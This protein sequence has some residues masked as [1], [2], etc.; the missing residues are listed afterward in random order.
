MVTITAVTPGTPAAKMENQVPDSLKHKHFDILL[1]VQNQISR[2]INV[3]ASKYD[4]RT[5]TNALW[6]ILLW[7]WLT[8]GIASIVW[9]H[10][11]C[12]RIGNELQRRQVPK[13][14][15]ASDFW[16]WCIL[17]A[18]IYVG[19]F[20]FVHKFMHAMNHLNADYNKKG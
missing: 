4:G 11:I 13:T 15:G 8:G 10:C 12:N 1:D 18:L 14:F 9:T 16:G 17:G 6:I 19:P 3:V 7:D 20:I 5:T 2:E